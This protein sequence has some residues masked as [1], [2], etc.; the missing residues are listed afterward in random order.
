MSKYN[1]LISHLPN[2]IV[3]DDDLKL[4]LVIPDRFEEFKAGIIKDFTHMKQWLPWVQEDIDGS[5]KEF[6]D[7]AV[8]KKEENKEIHWNILINEKLA[9]TISIL[10]RDPSG[11]CLEI[12]YW[13]FS[14][15]N[16]KGIMTRCAKIIIDL[17]FQQ[18][19]VLGVVI[20]CDKNNR[21]SASV[22]L[23]AGLKLDREDD[24]CVFGLESESGI[25]QN[26]K[27]TREQ[28]NI[29]K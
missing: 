15:N 22:A 13:L 3:I 5:S 7:S 23:R 2:E 17:V 18:T 4:S 21:L 11:E 26:Y 28:W 10:K 24:R 19:D 14:W 9:G 16:G 25:T 20:A 6:Y 12:G 29:L 1:I 8:L 27:I